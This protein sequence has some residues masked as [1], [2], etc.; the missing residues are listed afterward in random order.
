[1]PAMTLEKLKEQEASLLKAVSGADEPAKK[2]GLVKRLKRAQRRRRR[3]VTE[4][5]RRDK[6]KGKT[7][8]EG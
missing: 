4:L 8:S 2:R 5:A 1:M 7:E 3:M 6:G